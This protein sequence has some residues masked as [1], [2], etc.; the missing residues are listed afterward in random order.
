MQLLKSIN[1]TIFDRFGK[2]IASIHNFTS[3]GWDGSYNGKLLITNNYWFKAEII[4]KD[5]NLI[6]KS[7]NFS[8]IRN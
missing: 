5:D 6:K 2:I 3:P 4:D 8:L 7:G 1:V